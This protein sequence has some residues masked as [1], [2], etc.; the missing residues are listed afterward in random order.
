MKR[1]IKKHLLILWIV[2]LFTCFS[3]HAFAKVGPA[4]YYNGNDEKL[5]EY[6]QPDGR[7]EERFKSWYIRNNKISDE[8]TFDIGQVSL[9]RTKAVWITE[10]WTKEKFAEFFDTKDKVFYLQQN[11]HTTITHYAYIPL[12]YQGKY[13]NYASAYYYNDI[14]KM[15]FDF[16][17]PIEEY[18]SD[19]IIEERLLQKLKE[20]GLS[21]WIPQH[22]AV[23]EGF[24]FVLCEKG[25]ELIAVYMPSRYTIRYCEEFHE[26]FTKQRTFTKAQLLSALGD[27]QTDLNKRL[28]NQK[29]GPY[30]G[31]PV[32]DEEPAPRNN[33]LWWMIGGAVVLAGILITVALIL[34]KK[35]A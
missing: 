10:N 27:Y 4:F 14:A 22:I 30:G 20:F 34:A 17:N 33:T 21:D 18:T 23:V 25:N 12:Y 9:D 32:Y 11:A 1:Y 2:L 16:N 6:L 26:R 7:I 28:K 24:T 5:K 3:F 19:L 13:Q 29:P 35:K 31:G 15:Y 8:E